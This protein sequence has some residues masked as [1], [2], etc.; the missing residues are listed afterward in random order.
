MT[1]IELQQQRKSDMRESS[2]ALDEW[3]KI[4]GS[5]EWNKVVSYFEDRYIEIADKETVESI[6]QL[7]DRNARLNEIKRFFDFVKHDFNANLV[8]L[9]MLEEN[10][11]IDEDSPIPYVPY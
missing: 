8:R 3:K 6:K 2:L 9:R 5:S 11:Q 4:I 10:R 1:E 7:S